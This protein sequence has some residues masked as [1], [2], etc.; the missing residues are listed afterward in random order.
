MLENN[1]WWDSMKQRMNLWGGVFD[2]QIKLLKF[3]YKW[4]IV[5]EEIGSSSKCSQIAEWNQQ[6]QMETQM[7]GVIRHLKNDSFGCAR[8]VQIF[9]RSQYSINFNDIVMKNSNE[10]F[11]EFHSFF[12][13]II[14]LF[15]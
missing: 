12:E 1:S 7:D 14:I 10:K 13:I 8:T 3:L 9:N 5:I 6:L 11:V 2:F 4:Q 15:I